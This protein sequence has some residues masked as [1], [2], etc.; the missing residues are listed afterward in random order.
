VRSVGW[1]HGHRCKLHHNPP[2]LTE[3]RFGENLTS[4]TET[5]RGF[6]ARKS[7]QEHF[8]DSYQTPQ[9]RPATQRFSLFPTPNI[10]KCLID[11]RRES[12]KQL[13]KTEVS[14][15]RK[16]RSVRSEP[17]V[18]KRSEAAVFAFF[19]LLVIIGLERYPPAASTRPGK[20]DFNLLSNCELS[21]LPGKHNLAFFL[22]PR[23]P[24][25]SLR[26]LHELFWTLEK[27]DSNFLDLGATP[28]SALISSNQSNRDG[29]I[30]NHRHNGACA[31]SV[32]LPK[33]RPPQIMSRGG[34][35]GNYVT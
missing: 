18:M 31:T 21:D 19:S 2:N 30:P 22:G 27:L 1:G 32:H 35:S 6:V 29:T 17:S 26:K 25:L 5:F 24:L 33:S 23:S 13:E 3:K 16:V 28:V 12:L 15:S 8:S 20:Q 9:I 34:L 11:C 7:H 10:L 4:S 14:I